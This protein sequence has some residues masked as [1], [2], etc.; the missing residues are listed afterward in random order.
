MG[1]ERSDLGRKYYIE[2]IFDDCDDYFKYLL[3][4]IALFNGSKD[5]TP[6]L[7]KII[8]DS[9]EV[10]FDDNV[11]YPKYTMP[12]FTGTILLL[13]PSKGI[14]ASKR[15]EIRQRH[16][17]AHLAVIKT[18][19]INCAENFAMRIK[20]LDKKAPTQKTPGGAK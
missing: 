9:F 6:S 13:L 10:I 12:R 11:E 16:L 19:E 18:N 14:Q 4:A 5:Y 1:K 7:Q 2:D 8:P 20:I 17:N 3:K 15:E